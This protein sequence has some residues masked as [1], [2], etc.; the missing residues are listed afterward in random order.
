MNWEVTNGDFD[1]NV[2]PLATLKDEKG[3]LL[4]CMSKDY[5]TEFNMLAAAPDMLAALEGLLRT[6]KADYDQQTT[7][8]AKAISQAQAAVRKALGV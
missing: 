4:V 3:R 5:Q 2:S 7:E 6:F 8:R 1:C